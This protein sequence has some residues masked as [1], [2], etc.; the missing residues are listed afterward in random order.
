V[1]E[2]AA[3]LERAELPGEAIEAAIA[4][5]TE[6]GYL[7]DTRFARVFA[8][9]RRHLDGWGSDRIARSL[10]E[11]GIDGELISLVTSVD[12][13]DSELDRAKAILA[14]RFPAPPSDPRDQQRA[15]GVLVRKGYDSEVAYDAVRAWAGGA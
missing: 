11:R 7:D 8:E 14:R 10:A 6:L 13:G 1:G 3:R 12:A 4:E 9:D 15:L 5:L 2:V